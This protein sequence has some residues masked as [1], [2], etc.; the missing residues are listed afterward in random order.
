MPPFTGFYFELP[1]TCTRGGLALHTFG[2]HVC[3]RMHSCRKGGV[4]RW[5]VKSALQHSG[6]SLLILVRIHA[7]LRRVWGSNYSKWLISL[8]TFKCA[9]SAKSW[10]FWFR[11]IFCRV[12]RSILQ[13]FL[14]RVKGFVN[15][16]GVSVDAWWMKGVHCKV[17]PGIRIPSIIEWFWK[18][19][20]FPAMCSA[21]ATN[22]SASC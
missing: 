7:D 22:Y 14:D 21:P 4:S 2:P 18:A 10:Y 15:M 8:A 19:D 20:A 1:Y 5:A 12:T 11:H 9:K 13:F 17:V 16:T 3:V 6:S